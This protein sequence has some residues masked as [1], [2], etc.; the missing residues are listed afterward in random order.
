MLWT[1]QVCTAALSAVYEKDRT[2]V[3]AVYERDRTYVAV[4][5]HLPR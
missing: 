5:K 2:K 1:A 3:A 4:L